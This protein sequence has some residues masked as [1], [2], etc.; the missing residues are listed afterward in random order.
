MPVSACMGY[1]LCIC[2]Q[3]HMHLL[4]WEIINVWF[5]TF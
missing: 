1:I 2:Y 3:L 5:N 4:N